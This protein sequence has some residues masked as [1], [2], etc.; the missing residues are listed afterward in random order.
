MLRKSLIRHSSLALVL[1]VSTTHIALA[2]APMQRPNDACGLC[3]GSEENVLILI[4]LFLRVSICTRL[5]QILIKRVPT[6]ENWPHY[7]RSVPLAL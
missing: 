5:Q 7:L 6:Y 1:D 2:V 3:E 4:A